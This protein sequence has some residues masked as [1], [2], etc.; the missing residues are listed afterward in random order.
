MPNII[1][2]LFYDKFDHTN[3]ENRKF[4][5]KTK[6]E[7]KKLDKYPKEY[8]TYFNDYIPLKNEIRKLQS[9]IDIFIFNDLSINNF[10]LG[11]NG[12]FFLKNE[13]T[14]ISEQYI[15]VDSEYFTPS[16][17]EEAKNNLIYFRDR[18]KERNIDF[19]LMVCNDKRF[20]YDNYIPDYIIRKNKQ[21]P[22]EQFLEYITNK[23]DIKV[24]YT[25]NELYKYKNEYELYLKYDTHWNYLGAYIGYSEIMKKLNYYVKDINNVVFDVVKNDL[26]MDIARNLALSK[27]EYVDYDLHKPNGYY[28]N[29]V[30]NNYL[31]WYNFETFCYNSTNFDYIFIIR[32]SFAIAM[33]DYI[34]STFSRV[35]YEHIDYFRELKCDI[36]PNILIFETVERMLKYR[37]LNIIP[38]Y[39]IEEIN[40]NLE[41]NY[42]TNN[43]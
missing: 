7:L 2:N 35:H 11:K 25:K 1:Y 23:T 34:S 22:T 3:Y 31:N 24:I 41:T 32:D 30:T 14:R 36:N 28:S 5:E 21:S 38:N 42:I 19:I 16:Q 13:W 8:E 29:Y 10:I 4:S 15:G 43:N 40:N 37:I 27:L 39:K 17:L 6:F 33:Q 20:I 18:L 9:L 12:W 26:N